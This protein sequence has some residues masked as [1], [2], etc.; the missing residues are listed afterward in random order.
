MSSVDS[1]IISMTYGSIVLA[2]YF[3]SAAREP[4]PRSCGLFAPYL[5]LK[6]EKESLS[7]GGAYPVATHPTRVTTF[8]AAW[9]GQRRVH[10]ADSRRIREWDSGTEP[11]AMSRRPLGKEVS[12]LPVLPAR[13]GPSS[14][15]GSCPVLG[16]PME[17][18]QTGWPFLCRSRPERNGRC[19]REFRATDARNS[20]WGA[21]IGPEYDKLSFDTYTQ[22]QLYVYAH[23]TSTAETLAQSHFSLDM[24]DKRCTI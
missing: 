22:V 4:A 5:H 20:T 8:T 7:A 10:T 15:P 23:K 1:T 6:V 3:Q 17:G 21:P 12:S 9:P 18:G 16:L 24:D 14:P 11:A 19:M 13:M 2:L